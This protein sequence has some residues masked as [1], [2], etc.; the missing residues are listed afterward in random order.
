MPLE[1]EFSRS[2]LEDLE[3]IAGW[4]FEA[5]GHDV[6]RAYVGRIRSRCSG[7]ALFPDRGTP[8]YDLKP[9]LRS[10][11]FERRATIYYEPRADR[12]IIVRIL[13]GGR[14]PGRAFADP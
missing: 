2:A 11:P 9:G 1:I 3:G 4:L 7:L 5:A 14:D 8:H 10:I 12:L 13:H 6:A